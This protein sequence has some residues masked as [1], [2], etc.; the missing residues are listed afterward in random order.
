MTSTTIKRKLTTYIDQIDERMLMA[1]YTMLDNYIHSMSDVVGY[2]ADGRSI[3]KAELINS[4]EKSAS[5]IKS[6]KTFTQEQ[7]EKRFK[8]KIYGKA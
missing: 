8:E 3:T 7:V 1:V 5:D 2:E 6:G 4:I